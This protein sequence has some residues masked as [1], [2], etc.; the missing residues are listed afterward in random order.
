M[1]QQPSGMSSQQ[2]QQ[3]FAQFMAN[4][5]AAK[6][7]GRTYAK[8][9]GLGKKFLDFLLGKD[10][11]LG[12]I[13]RGEIEKFDSVKEAMD[14]LKIYEAYIGDERSRRLMRTALGSDLEEDFEDK[15]IR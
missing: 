9:V 3:A 6:Q 7:R 1:S 8:N 12:W 5:V 2:F 11:K 15:E 4:L 13:A 14:Y 10:P